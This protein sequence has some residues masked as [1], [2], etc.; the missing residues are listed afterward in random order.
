MV[1]TLE[2]QRSRL[3]RVANFSREIQ[4]DLVRRRTR[5]TV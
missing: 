1:R 2:I 5:T 3:G 4:L